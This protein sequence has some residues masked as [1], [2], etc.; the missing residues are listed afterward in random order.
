[1]TP[2]MTSMTPQRKY[3]ALIQ[4]N[5]VCPAAI[6]AGVR[7]ID[8]QERHRQEIDSATHDDAND[9][10]KEEAGEEDLID[11]LC[12]SGTVVLAYKAYHGLMNSVHGDVDKVFNAGSLHCF[13][14]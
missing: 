1:M 9:G 12:F 10:N 7:G 5:L 13:L 14:P 8:G 3:G 4:N 2:M 11:P 6:T